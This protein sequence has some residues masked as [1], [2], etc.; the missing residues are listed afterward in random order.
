VRG[1]PPSRRAAATWRLR[2]APPSRR[3]TATRGPR[4]GGPWRRRGPVALR[5]AAAA[6]RPSGTGVDAAPVQVPCPALAPRR[7]GT[8]AAR[9]GGRRDTRGP[10]G[11][12]RWRAEP[13]G[14]PKQRW[15]RGGE[16][17]R[18]AAGL[19]ALC[20]ARTR[21]STSRLTRRPLAAQRLDRA[22]PH[23]H[24][25]RGAGSARA[26]RRSQSTRPR[27]RTQR[28]LVRSRAGC[29]ASFRQGAR[30]PPCPADRAASGG[31]LPLPS[32]RHPPAHTRPGGA[33]VSAK[34]IAPLRDGR[35]AFAD[36]R[37]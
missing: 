32:H 17:W 7:R 2:A 6:A 23:G 13:P 35:R 26:P 36:R 3:R 25:L 33:L 31:L 34:A 19:S 8:G 15:P 1:P 37:L 9:R 10:V 22:W 4:F 28:S 20:D 12:R 16:A 14:G 5:R 21:A 29:S 18:L 27:A 11:P 24:A 30:G